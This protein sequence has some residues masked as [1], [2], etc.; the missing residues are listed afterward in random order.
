MASKLLEHVWRIEA[1]NEIE[2]SWKSEPGAMA[3]VYSQENLSKAIGT[4]GWC[5]VWVEPF[6][7]NVV[8]HASA[9]H[10]PGHPDGIVFGHIHVERPYRGWRMAATLQRKRGEWLDRHD[11]TLLGAVAKGNDVSLVGSLKSGFRIMQHDADGST[12]VARIPSRQRE[13]DGE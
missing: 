1:E 9:Y 11:F 4:P 10:L 13:R 2:G 5:R 7:G 3:L 8:G 12:W 6:G